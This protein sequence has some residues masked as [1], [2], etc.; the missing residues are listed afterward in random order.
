MLEKACLEEGEHAGIQRVEC[1]PLKFGRSDFIG[2]W[3]RV[4]LWES[5]AEVS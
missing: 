2:V 4:R 1:L 3:S 5:V